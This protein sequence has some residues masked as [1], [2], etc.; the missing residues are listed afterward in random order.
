MLLHK[1]VLSCCVCTSWFPPPGPLIPPFLNPLLLPS[2]QEN[3]S[4]ALKLYL[5]AGSVS[6]IHFTKEVPSSVW[7]AHAYQRM[8][9]CCT[10]VQLPAHVGALRTAPHATHYARLHIR[11]P[12]FSS[13]PSLSSSPVL[14]LSSSLSVFP[15]PL[16]PPISKAIVLCQFWEPVDY[17]LAFS[18]IRESN[19]CV[20]RVDSCGI[21]A[22][23][24]YLYACPPPP[25]PPPTSPVITLIC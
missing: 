8:L 1:E 21:C 18:L 22:V 23:V 2:A 9:A 25:P 24:S 20:R 16:P 6:S 14:I 19:M 3:Y 4:S 10:A 17:D 7:T 12:L 11:P 13:S 15:V 5:E